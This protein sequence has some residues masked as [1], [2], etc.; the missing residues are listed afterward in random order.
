MKAPGRRRDAT[1]AGRGRN[2]VWIA[3]LGAA[4]CTQGAS[5]D[6]GEAGVPGQSP[7]EMFAWIERIGAHDPLAEL[8]DVHHQRYP[9]DNIIN[10]RAALSGLARKTLRARMMRNEPPDTFQANAGD[11]LMQWVLTNGTD[12]R[13]SKLLPLD[14][15]VPNIASL[16]LAVP[17]AL[18]ERVSYDGKIYGIPANI[19]R[20]NLL[21]YNKKLMA[22]YGLAEPKTVDDLLAMGAKLLGTG[23]PLISLGS[24][25]PWTVSL[26]IFDNILVAREG[27]DFCRDYFAGR[28]AADDPRVVRTLRTG[29]QLLLL[30]NA[31]HRDLSW[32]QGVEMVVQGKAVMTVMGAWARATFKEHGMKLGVDYDEIPFPGSA[33]TFVFSSDAFGLPTNAENRAG[34]A[35]LLGTLGSIEGQ[36]AVNQSR[37]TL[38]ARIDV[39]PP[40]ASPQLAQGHELL[41]QGKM[42]I[43]LWGILPGSVAMDLEAALGEMLDQKDIDPV[44]QTLRSRYALFK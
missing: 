31:D 25:A 2:A 16:R 12:A 6:H 9:E 15:L 19:L 32:L 41:M 18:L 21:F 3:L 10:A 22:K 23:M 44:V 20:N 29:L 40:P 39:A 30:A 13:E 1:A 36:R 37:G 7:I 38:S 17:A 5:R 35:R 8:V 24:R 43:A 34:A 14:D 33:D 42:L 11:D 28:L 4:G 26:L 27:P